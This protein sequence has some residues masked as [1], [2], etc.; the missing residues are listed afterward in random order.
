MKTVT[1]IFLATLFFT[2]EPTQKENLYSWQITFNSF[3]QCEQFYNEFGAKLLNGVQDHAKR[4]YGRDAQVEYLS[5]AQVEVDPS[6]L[7]EGYT[8]PKV[9]DQRVMYKLEQTK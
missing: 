8:H 2:E 6:M 5:C 1:F 3:N 4:T 7:Q 9:I